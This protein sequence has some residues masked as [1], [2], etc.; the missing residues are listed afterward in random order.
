[1]KSLRTSILFIA[2]FF[3]YSCS[4]SKVKN[5]LTR[6]NLKGKVMTL[7]ETAYS[8]IEKSGEVQK[9][10]FV[11]K[12]N[13]KYDNK[14]DKIEEKLYNPDG[15]LTQKSTYEYDESGNQIVESRYNSTGSLTQKFTYEYDNNGNLSLG[16]GYNSNGRL[17]GKF[18]YAYDDRSNLI[19]ES[20]YNQDNK[21]SW[22]FTYKHDDKGNQIEMNYYNY[23]QD[24]SFLEKTIYK[25]GDY[26]ITGNWLKKTTFENDKPKGITE[27]K[28]EY[29]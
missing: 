17:W 7:T 1:M 11:S 20:M 6:E 3:L 23:I 16:N 4:Q 8:I 28:I 5:D 29:Y 13:Y 14:G 25:Y 2:A 12:F 22:K 10:N 21:L 18:R 15:S 26:D 24:T 19:E 27:R 9:G